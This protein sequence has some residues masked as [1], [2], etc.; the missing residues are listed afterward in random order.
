MNFKILVDHAVFGIRAHRCAAE[1]VRGGGQVEQ[2]LADGAER[3]TIRA[4]GKFLG[5]FMRAFHLRVDG[6][7]GFFF[8]DHAGA[9]KCENTFAHFET[10]TIIRVLHHEQDGHIVRPAWQ[11]ERL[12]K[13]NGMSERPAKEIENAAWDAEVLVDQ[14]RS[15]ET[16]ERRAI[17]VTNWLDACDLV[18][19]I[20]R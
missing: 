9:E 8:R 5:H 14:R 20:D 13:V 7:A 15:K 10:H 19:V 2:I 12:C 16:H 11:N 17:R 6:V 18:V 1:D 4:F 3:H